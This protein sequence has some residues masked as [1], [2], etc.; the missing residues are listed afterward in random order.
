MK[1]RTANS[2][3][4][5]L[6]TFGLIMIMLFCG[7]V[8]YYVWV[9]IVVT[10]SIDRADAI[11]LRA[12]FNRWFEAGR[13]TGERLNQFIQG[14]RPDLVVSNYLLVTPQGQFTSQFALTN[15]HGHRGNLFVDTNGVLIFLPPSGRAELHPLNQRMH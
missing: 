9:R 5:L 2:A 1:V 15:L 13:P 3:G 8:A 12:A 11:E 10:Q 14:R 7:A 4:S 6:A